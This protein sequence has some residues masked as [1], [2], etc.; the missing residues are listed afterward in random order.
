MV[1]NR[2]GA[3][4]EYEGATFTIGQQIVGT[5]HG[6]YEGLYGFITEIRDGDDKETE[7]D[8]PDIYCTFEPPVLPYDV[9]KLEKHFSEL[10]QKPQKLVD[11]RLD[12]I[13]MAPE[14]I[15]GVED[16]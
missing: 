1:V 12:E 13:I 5:D 4:Y 16:V 8:T 10:Y 3:I 6:D 11:I 9:E 15:K 2:I 7:N 14:M